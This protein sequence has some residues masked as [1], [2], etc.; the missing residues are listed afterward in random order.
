MERWR[1]INLGKVEPLMAQTFYE[2]VASAVDKGL[3]PN[4]IILC[5]PSRHYAC[6]GFHQEAE[7]ELDIEYCHSNN[8]PIIRRSQGGG[9]TYL[10]S[11]QIFYQVIG[12]KRS[13][14]IPGSVEKLFEK[15][16]RITVYVYRKLGLPAEFKALNDVVVRGKK[17]SGNGAGELGSVQ[18]LVGNI[19]LGLDYDSMARVLK[20]PSEKFRDKMFKSMK[21]WVTSLKRELGYTPSVKEIKKLLV[22]GYESIL[23]IKLIPSEPSDAEKRIWIEEVKPRNLSRE[24]LY[25]QKKESVDGR[26]VKVADGVKVVEVDYKAKKMIRIRAELIGDK[27]L[28]VMLSGDF[29]MI[30]RDNL[31][32]LELSLKDVTLRRNEVLEKIREF[33]KKTNVQTP[34]ITPEDFAEAIM[35]LRKLAETYASAIYPYSEVKGD[36]LAKAD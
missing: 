27:I 21:K 7:K 30:P 19:I 10:D 36:E 3:S 17:I 1:L 28:D 34:G 31:S 29:F 35:K 32:K 6:L 33:Y 2:A 12:S 14:V 9:A 8:I 23:G 15:L 24:W 16:L 26:A 20:V 25:R 4:T 18:I 11:N 13:G 22:E 5:Q